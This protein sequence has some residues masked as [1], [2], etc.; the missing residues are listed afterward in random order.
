[1]AIQAKHVAEYFLKISKFED[2]D[3]ISN[4]K[5]QKLVYYAQ[6]F[7]LAMYGEPLFQEKIYAWV[8]GPVVG[9]LYDEYKIHGGGAIPIPDEFDA[10][11]FN[12]NQKNLLD[13]VFEVYGQFSAWKLREMTHSELPWSVTNRNDEIGVVQ[14]K[15]FFMTQLNG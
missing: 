13:E 11:V 10:E 12:S 15:E 6:G 7:H 14:M 4:L 9:E 1:M 3:I 2:G 5:I 8:H